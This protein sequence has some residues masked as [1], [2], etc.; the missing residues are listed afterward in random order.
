VQQCCS[1]WGW[2][3]HLF[4]SDRSTGQLQVGEGSNDPKMDGSNTIN[5]DKLEVTPHFSSLS[6][7]FLSLFSATCQI[8]V[9]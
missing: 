9:K 5:D 6:L 1:E 8:T 2:K 7:V 3:E 4:F